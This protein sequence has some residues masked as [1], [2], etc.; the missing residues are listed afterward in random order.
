MLL[1]YSKTNKPNEMNDKI[2][3]SFINSTLISYQILTKVYP[4]EMYS[5]PKKGWTGYDTKLYPVERL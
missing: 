5:A 1:V 4:A 3:N 2:D